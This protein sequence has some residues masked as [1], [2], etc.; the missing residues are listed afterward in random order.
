MNEH[1]IN[2]DLVV[3]N[4]VG[5]NVRSVP[6][7]FEPLPKPFHANVNVIY[8]PRHLD[9]NV[10]ERINRYVIYDS[11]S[12]GTD[13]NDEYGGIDRAFSRDSPQY[14]YSPEGNQFKLARSSDPCTELY[15]E[16]VKFERNTYG[17]H[18]TEEQIRY[19]MDDFISQ[20]HAMDYNELY[21]LIHGVHY[22]TYAYAD[23]FNESIWCTTKLMQS[24]MFRAYMSDWYIYSYLIL[25]DMFDAI[26]SLIKH[27][28]YDTHPLDFVPPYTIIHD[29]HDRTVSLGY[30]VHV[31]YQFLFKILAYSFDLDLYEWLQRHYDTKTS[32]KVD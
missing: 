7:S 14:G 20:L 9:I 27:V 8:L 5:T 6:Y 23:L 32:D 12:N 24:V 18:M 21:G 16:L 30:N 11:L 10:L 29:L 22:L 31:I 2:R 25:N 26:F 1:D 13:V 4:N 19:G 15:R 17:M 28:I 3:T